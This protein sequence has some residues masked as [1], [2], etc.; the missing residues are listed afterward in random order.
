MGRART[1]PTDDVHSTTWAPPADEL[2]SIAEDGGPRHEVC[3][4][5]AATTLQVAVRCEARGARHVDAN[6]AAAQLP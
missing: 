3:C 1:V 5:R 2:E 4:L 6:H